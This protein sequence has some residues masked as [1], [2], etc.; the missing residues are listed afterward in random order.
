MERTTT[1][2]GSVDGTETMKEIMHG[3]GTMEETMK[4]FITMDNLGTMKGTITMDDLGTMESSLDGFETSINIFLFQASNTS[5]FLGES[6][7]SDKIVLEFLISPF[8]DFT[9]RSCFVC[10]ST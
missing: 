2:D 1:M 7:N 5:S 4:G 10:S 3:F 8:L 9:L 6:K